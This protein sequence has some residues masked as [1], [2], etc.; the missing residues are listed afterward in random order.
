MRCS[1]LHGCITLP[2]REVKHGEFRS[3][4][5]TLP[6]S[7][8]TLRWDYFTL[9]C[10]TSEY[11]HMTLIFKY[12]GSDQRVFRFCYPLDS[13]SLY[14]ERPGGGDDVHVVVVKEDHLLR[15]TLQ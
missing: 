10:N 12:T 8:Q 13:D 9:D 3:K 1:L 14:T 6:N 5:R 15:L 2:V 4:T 7:R 11:C